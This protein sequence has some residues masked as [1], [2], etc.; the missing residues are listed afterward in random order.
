MKEGLKLLILIHSLGQLSFKGC[1]MDI[2]SCILLDSG[3]QQTEN[4]CACQ[5][6]VIF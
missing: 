4:N 5:N 1:G 2:L 6:I 3:P